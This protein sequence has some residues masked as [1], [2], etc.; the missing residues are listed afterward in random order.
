MISSYSF[1]SKHLQQPSLWRLRNLA[2]LLHRE[3]RT[4]PAN[5]KPE[6]DVIVIGAGEMDAN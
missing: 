5:L 2:R 3:T 4:D 1:S 6:Y